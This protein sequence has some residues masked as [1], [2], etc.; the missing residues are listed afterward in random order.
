M[1]KQEEKVEETPKKKFDI[2]GWLTST[3]GKIAL[4]VGFFVGY[5]ELMP[6]IKDVLGLTDDMKQ[7]ELN[8]NAYTDQ[9][10]EEKEGKAEMYLDILMNDVVEIKEELRQD[11]IADAQK[12]WFAVG[13][14]ANKDGA[15]IYRDRFQAQ[16]PVRP[17]FVEGCYYYRDHEGDWIKCYFE[18]P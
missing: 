13:L 18:K 10:I 14:R 11:S 6:I 5:Q 7:T 4:V 15:Y 9:K 12:E 2:W 3:N 8:C 16:Y 17:D 1:G